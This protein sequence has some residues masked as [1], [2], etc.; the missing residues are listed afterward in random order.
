MFQIP[1]VLSLTQRMVLFVAFNTSY[2]LASYFRGTA[3]CITPAYAA[4]T[5]EGN[6]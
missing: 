5:D 4:M 6:S 3:V 1:L 2:T